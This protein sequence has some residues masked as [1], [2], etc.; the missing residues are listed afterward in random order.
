MA[1]IQSSWHCNL[2]LRTLRCR[3]TRS[4]GYNKWQIANQIC[5]SPQRTCSSYV[6]FIFHR[7]L[8]LCP[9]WRIGRGSKICKLNGIE[10]FWKVLT[11]WIG[12]I[13]CL[14]PHFRK[15]ISDMSCWLG[16]GLEHMLPGDLSVTNHWHMSQ[17][18]ITLLFNFLLKYSWYIM[19][20]YFQVYRI[21]II[22]QNLFDYTNSYFIINIKYSSLCYTVS[23]YC[24]SIL[25]IVVCIC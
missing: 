24:L 5:Q 22:F 15:N 7:V 18:K 23:P 16:N 11:L 21:Y 12:I 6:S 25:Y 10:V 3:K 2:Q 17:Y 9:L 14:S 1:K 20:C 13:L 19:L 4:K 8:F